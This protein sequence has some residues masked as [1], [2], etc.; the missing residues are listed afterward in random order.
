MKQPPSI[1]H[2]HIKTQAKIKKNQNKSK[3][4][5]NKSF[6][7]FK[8]LIFWERRGEKREKGK[9]EKKKRGKKEEGKKKKKKK[10]ITA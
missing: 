10:K 6:T 7:K 8:T 3:P 1:K 4:S 2:Q 5:L 9:K